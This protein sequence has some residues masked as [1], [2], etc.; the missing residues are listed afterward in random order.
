MLQFNDEGK[1]YRDLAKKNVIETKTIPSN[2]GSIYFDDGS[3]FAT[4]VSKYDIHFDAMTAKNKL[5]NK[6]IKGLADSLEAYFGKPSE[7]YERKLRLARKNKNR[8]NP[9]AKNINYSDYRRFKSFPLLDTTPYVGG[10]IISQKTKREY[11]MGEI[12]HRTIGYE[13]K[14]ANGNITRAGIDGAF[15][16]K[17]LRGTDGKRLMQLLQKGKWKPIGDSNHIEPKDGYD[18]YTSLNINMQDIVHHALLNQL[19][20]YNAEHGCAVVMEVKTGEVKAISNLAKTAKGKY[21]EK[22]NFAVWESHEPGSTFKVMSLM[23][24]LEHGLIDTSTIVDTKKG[25][26]QFYN[27]N[28]TDSK[29]GGFGKITAAKAL[30]VSSNIGIATLLDEH[31]SQN[32]KK[33]INQLKKWKLNSPLNIPIQGEGLP[34]IPEPGTKKWSKNALPSMAY[35]YNLEL[36]PLQTLTFYNAI[37]NNGIMVKPKFVNA[38]KEFDQNIKVFESEIINEKIASKTTINKMQHILKN[39]VDRGTGKSLRSKYFSMAGKTGTAQTEYWKKNWSNNKK[40]I[41]SFAGY[42]PADEPKY[43]CIVVIHKPSIE[44]GY[45]GADVS[46]PVFKKIA[47][48]IYI[49]SPKTELLKEN[50][51]IPQTVLN[52][53]DTYFKIAR[54]Y[55]TIMPNLKG[56]P[57]MDAITILENLGLKVKTKGLGNVK[58]QSIEQGVKLKKNQ[59]VILD[60]S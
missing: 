41:S 40:Y 1:K 51:K 45:Y 22:R 60:L 55:K 9:I 35:G 7:I 42:F 30:E 18:V 25:I 54:K 16:D 52:N 3:L 28:I 58:H 12:A 34:D 53:F 39:V 17:Y 44:K 33:F 36:T 5:F 14:D 2:R 50:N 29:N 57:A 6:K 43:S 26:K 56:L 15:G 37:A 27:R 13:R 46:G 31:Y 49:D 21:F 32:P 24:L 8:Y 38:I 48:K 11:P 10:I 47:R 59:T 4:S 19:E 20:Y 23:A